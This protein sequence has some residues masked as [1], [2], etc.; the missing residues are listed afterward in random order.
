MR[1]V[2]GDISKISPFPEREKKSPCMQKLNLS[3]IRNF[4]ISAEGLKPNLDDDVTKVPLRLTRPTKRLA[5]PQSIEDAK[6]FDL[7]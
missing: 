7:P 5:Q 3:N 6:R 4:F 1:N 2:D